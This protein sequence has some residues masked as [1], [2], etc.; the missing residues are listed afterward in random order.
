MS[1]LLPVHIVAG[2]V[3]IITGTIALFTL[4]GGMRHRRSGLA[5][6]VAMSVMASM[7]A[8]ISLWPPL[9]PGNVFQSVLT[10]YM[11]VTGMRA[12]RDRSDRS[13]RGDVALLL[14][15]L[16]VAAGHASFGFIAL[17]SES[18]AIGGYN[19]PMF[20]IFG[21][22][23]LLAVTGDVRMLRGAE[24]R[25][26]VR[27]ARHLWRM[28]FA[29][30][31][32][33]GS[34]FLGQADEF[35]VWL[36]IWPILTVLA[37]YPLAG[38]IYWLW[39][40]R[41]RRSLRGLISRDT[42]RMSAAAALAARGAGAALAL[43]AVLAAG[44]VEAA[45]QCPAT[46]QRHVDAM[47]WEEA[48][49]AAIAD[50]ARQR[51]VAAAHACVGL[52]AIGLDA[53]DD[54]ASAY[55]RAVELEPGN[56]EYRLA[57]GQALALEAARSGSPIRQIRL[58]RRVKSSFEE[59]IRLDPRMVDARV[60][61]VM[62]HSMAPR[63]MG[64]DRERAREN[65]TAITRLNA[66]RGHMAEALLAEQQDDDAAAE[67]AY[68]SAASV[69]GPD[70]VAGHL[71]LG[72]FYEGRQRWSDAFALY[73]RLLTEFAGDAEVRA[74]YG[75]AAARSGR[76]LEQGEREL[77]AWLANRPAGTGVAASANVHYWLGSVLQ[78]RGRIDEARAEYRAAVRLSARHE[79]ARDAL[80]ELD[81]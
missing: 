61:L 64:G 48:R 16:G 27:I 46:V 19:P 35:P 30:F 29:L 14:L 77:R 21:S 42:V 49:S 34:F 70:S 9:N 37:L 44:A 78:K 7:A 72:E 13:V 51:T 28:C 40:V 74:S 52:V 22:I 17:N 10:I 47:R 39:R 69:S 33:N 71:A 54:A 55:E 50:A 4:K 36:R 3:G 23:A 43:A 41:L 79:A 76:N 32:A 81:E 57:L 31:I 67:R 26:P 58:A 53:T 25:A 2:T 24:L 12:V 8:V 66:M 62:F 68:R 11:V 80:A 6:V 45:A 60:W 75:R 5:F 38:M 59:A 15:G 56:A 73:D 18:G 65:V 63:I 1:I 20:F